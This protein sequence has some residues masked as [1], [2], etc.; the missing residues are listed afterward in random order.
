MSLFF[1]LVLRFVEP[2]AA[3]PAVSASLLL[4]HVRLGL[5]RTVVL[6]SDYWI[7]TIDYKSDYPAP[8]VLLSILIIISQ[9]ELHGRLE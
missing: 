7:A 8:H 2:F 1:L 3:P 4:N 5:D 9:M 6:P